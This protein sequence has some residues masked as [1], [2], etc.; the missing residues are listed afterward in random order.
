M[1]DHDGGDE[2]RA[3]IDA[4]AEC[5]FCK[6]SIDHRHRW[7]TPMFEPMRHSFVEAIKLDAGKLHYD[8][9]T[10]CD[11]AACRADAVKMSRASTKY[12]EERRADAYIAWG[13]R[14]SRFSYRLPE[15][16]T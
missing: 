7:Q 16:R 6:R 12:E 15:T 1:I 4:G 13:L 5:P 14:T 9:L 11:S 3:P 10:T 8:T 2:D